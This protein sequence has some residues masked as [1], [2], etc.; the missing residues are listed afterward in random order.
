MMNYIADVTNNIQNREMLWI[1]KKN[2]ILLMN[3]STISAPIKVV[4]LCM[5]ILAVCLV[6][7]SFAERV[8]A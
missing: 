4:Q 7:S 6:S 2:L 1:T 3:D 8:Q 5:Y